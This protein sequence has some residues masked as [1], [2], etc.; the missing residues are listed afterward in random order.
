MKSLD[1]RVFS[2][3]TTVFVENSLVEG[4]Q[5]QLSFL[6]TERVKKKKRRKKEERQITNYQLCY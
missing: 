5:Q 3:F 2:E 4:L 6:G 1:T